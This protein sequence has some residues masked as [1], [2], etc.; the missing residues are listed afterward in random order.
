MKSSHIAL[1]L[2]INLIWGFS[3]LTAKLGLSEFPPLLFTTMRFGLVAV[4][5][6][7]YLKLLPGK[8]KAI[9]YV[10]VTSGSVHFVLLYLGIQAAGGVSAVAITI[11]LVAPF[12]LLLAVLFLGEHIGW[13][14]IFGITLAFA[15]VMVLGFDPIILE[16]LDGVILVAL[17]ALSVSG[18]LILMRKLQGVGVFELQAWVSAICFPQVLVL[19]LLFED[20][21]WEAI[22][23]ASLLGWGALVFSAVITTLIAHSGW[24][25]LI[26]RYAINIL[27][28]FGLL[29]P[30]FGVSFGVFLLNEPLSLRFIIGGA[31]TLFGVGI[32]N[33]RASKK[34]AP[35]IV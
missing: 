27:T 28:P 29:A 26:Q 1:A 19:S 23:N 25:F 16:Q 33:I 4:I 15:G 34:S 18:S 32:I 22:A 5:L 2:L 20:G 30:V 24:Y 12:S 31:I 11:Q 10:A 17:A 7:F 35:E 14:R 9:F 13:K 3:F 8:M 6:C 21:Q